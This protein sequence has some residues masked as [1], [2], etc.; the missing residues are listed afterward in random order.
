MKIYIKELAEL[1]SAIITSACCVHV[2][3]VCVGWG[4]GSRERQ[5][6]KMG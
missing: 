6:K 3:G 4:E 1:K 5:K 2:L